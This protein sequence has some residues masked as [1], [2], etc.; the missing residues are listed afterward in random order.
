LREASSPDVESDSE[1]HAPAV[2]GSRASDHDH[3]RRDDLGCVVAQN[4]RFDDMNKRFDDFKEF[5][6]HR[7]DAIEKR[8]DAIEMRLV[9]IGKELTEHGERITRLEGALLH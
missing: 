8:L 7:L 5:L 2:S 3:F 6:G 9:S 1:P 4:K